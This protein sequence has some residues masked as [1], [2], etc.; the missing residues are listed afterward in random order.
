MEEKFNQSKY[1]N[2]YNK[3]HYVSC[4]LRVK[5]DMNKILTEFSK[6]L[7]LSKA[8]LLQKCMVYC[9]ENMIDVSNI[10]IE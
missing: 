1:A 6:N 10:P 8:A 5:P 3:E 4:T 7:G 2:E 9:Y